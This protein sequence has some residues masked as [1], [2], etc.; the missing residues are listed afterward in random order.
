MKKLLFLLVT[1]TLF[2]GLSIAC[3]DTAQ[4]H[5]DVEFDQNIIMARYDVD[6]LINGKTVAFIKHGQYLDST[7]SVPHGMCTITFQKAGDADVS[8]TAIISI[9]KDT[10]VTCEIHANLGS[11]KFRSLETDIDVSDY[12]LN[13]GDS[14]T[15]NGIAIS[16]TGHRIVTSYNNY[17]PAAGNVYVIC[18]AEFANNNVKS[19]NTAS[20]MSAFSFDACYDDI[21][22]D[23]LW[24]AMYDLSGEFTT[25]K[26]FSIL[27]RLTQDI[28]SIR[29]GKK[30]VIELVFEV[31]EDW[32]VLELYYINDAI[33]AGEV[34][35][36]LN[37]D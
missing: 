37:N 36:V 6:V 4:L 16:I 8:G 31:P 28:E 18:Q 14:I 21:E 23:C 17:A 22:T 35:F 10:D 19:A 12:Q 1:L 30:A 2:T 5:L 7:F 15:I 29:P 32:K 13:E 11:V 20:M 33:A 27:E 26:A 9:T 34:S 25:G 3:A 24:S